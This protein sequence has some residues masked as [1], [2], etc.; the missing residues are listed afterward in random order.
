[1][2]WFATN[3][4]RTPGQIDRIGKKNENKCNFDTDYFYVR[5]R[6]FFLCTVEFSRFANDDAHG[7][8]NETVF[9]TSNMRTSTASLNIKVSRSAELRFE[10]YGTR[11]NYA[12]NPQSIFASALLGNSIEPVLGGSNRNVFY[13]QFQKTL[14]WGKS[15]TN[16]FASATMGVTVMRPVGSVAGRVFVDENENGIWDEGER[17]VASAIVT[18]NGLR[19]TTTD[20]LGRFEFASVPV[21]PNEVSLDAETVNA[22]FTPSSLHESVTI[23]FKGRAQTNFALRAASTISGRIVEKKGDGTVP[24]ADAAL[25][26][27]PGGL[28]AYTDA[29]GEFSISSVSRGQYELKLVSETIEHA[30]R[31]VSGPSGP[32]D[33]AQAGQQLKNI[34][35]VLEAVE[36]APEI[37]HLPPARILVKSTSN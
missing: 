25:R 23:A 18:L 14:R 3:P 26:L 28:Y 17:G 32:L 16:E 15:T 6:D 31:I 36:T 34:E 30:I 8:T 9:A 10:Y 22:I 24:V 27:E 2:A 33:I 20:D 7:A 19:K 1:M 29:A 11:L 12:L 13:V 5:I 21:G 37:E 35:F 4:T